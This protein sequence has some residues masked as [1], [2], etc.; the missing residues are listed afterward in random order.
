MRRVAH[1][2][3]DTRGAAGVEMA[4]VAPLLLTLLFGAVEIGNYFRAE[5]MLLKGVRDAAIYASRLSIENYDCTAGSPAVEA[6]VVDQVETLIRTGE[7]S[8]GTDTL[9]RWDDAAASVEMALVCKTQAGPSGALET[10]GGIYTLNG[11]QV[12]VITITATLPYQS[13][14]AAMG[15]DATSLSLN[16]VEEAAVT[17]V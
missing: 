6:A 16:A 1:L 3:R 11:G 8:G 4:L 13:L 14:I 7:L 12:P 5:H 10:M 9:P 2:L 15:F 17:G